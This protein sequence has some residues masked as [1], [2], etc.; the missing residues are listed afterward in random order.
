M[1][2]VQER[3]TSGSNSDVS[4]QSNSGDVA[5]AARDAIEKLAYERWLSRGCPTDSPQEDWF[6]AE[7]ALAATVGA[8]E[9]RPKEAQPAP[10]PATM[11]AGS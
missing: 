3:K 1:R 8:V 5:G 2:K 10:A 7:R 11:R 6:E 4:A 9:D